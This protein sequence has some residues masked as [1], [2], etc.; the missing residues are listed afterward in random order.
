MQP[1]RPLDVYAMTSLSSNDTSPMALA[2]LRVPYVAGRLREV[3][4]YS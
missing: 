2:P 1:Q 3:Q 4:P